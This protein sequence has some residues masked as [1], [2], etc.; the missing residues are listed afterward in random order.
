MAEYLF[1]VLVLL[2]SLLFGIFCIDKPERVYRLIAMW[3]RFVGAGMEDMMSKTVKDAIAYIDDPE[4]YHVL[5]PSVM[6]LVQ[7]TGFIALF[8]FIIG[9]CIFCSGTQ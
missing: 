1:R 5:F 9:F 7:R 3:T 2:F 6:R 8:V 4:Q